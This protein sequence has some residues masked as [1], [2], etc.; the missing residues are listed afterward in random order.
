MSCGVKATP[1]ASRKK[2][3]T[4]TGR[5]RTKTEPWFTFTHGK[6]GYLLGP[7][8]RVYSIHMRKGTRFPLKRQTAV[9]GKLGKRDKVTYEVGN[10]D[11]LIHAWGRTSSSNT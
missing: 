10:D 2:R 6:T 9:F 3:R 5:I 7:R 11:A 8:K 4:A 1:S